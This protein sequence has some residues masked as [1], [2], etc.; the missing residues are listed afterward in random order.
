MLWETVSGHD[1]AKEGHLKITAKESLR[2]LTRHFGGGAGRGRGPG[3]H[4]WY[5]FI[6]TVYLDNCS[7]YLSVVLMDELDQVVT[8]KQ[9]VIYNFFNW[10]TIANSKLIVIAVANTHDLP[11]RVMTGR[12]RSRLGESFSGFSGQSCL[13]ILGMKRINFQPYKGEQLQEI[14]QT[15]LKTASDSLPNKASKEVL[16][17]DAIKLAAMKVSGIT[18][19]CRRILDICRYVFVIR[20]MGDDLTVSSFRVDGQ[21]NWFVN[22]GGQPE[23]AISLKS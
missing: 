16:K 19:D 22:K 5:V 15:R 3:D 20:L 17:E 13:G 14:V 2:S 10:P 11:E 23:Q 1:V 12:V 7:I 21:W 4:A 8:S 18:G 6:P 9:D